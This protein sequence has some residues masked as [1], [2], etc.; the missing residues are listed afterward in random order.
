M[1][2]KIFKKA[3]EMTRRFVK[4]YGVDYQAQFGLCLSFLFEEKEEKEMEG[5]ITDKIFRAAEEVTETSPRKWEKFGKKR[6]YFNYGWDKNFF[7]AFPDTNTVVGKANRPGAVTEIIE[8][9]ELCQLEIV[10]T[11]GN[12]V[13][14]KLRRNKNV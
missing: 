1:L 9:F 2:S 8:A 5:T 11:A 6:F 4:E 12:K 3:H 13:I 14:A 7:L 10:D